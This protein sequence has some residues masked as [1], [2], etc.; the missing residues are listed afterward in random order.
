M[1]LRRKSKVYSGVSEA[2]VSGTT[3][4]PSQVI[5]DY[6]L[7][8]LDKTLDY[9]DNTRIGKLDSVKKKTSRFAGVVKPLK[10]I[11]ARKKKRD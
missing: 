8:P 2:M 7:E 3:Y 10:K 1:K 11:L 4:Y 5:T 6:A 9:I